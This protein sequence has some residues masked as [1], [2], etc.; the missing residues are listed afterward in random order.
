[1]RIL[2]AD[3]NDFSAFEGNEDSRVARR[4]RKFGIFMRESRRICGTIGPRRV[5][6]VSVTG[7]SWIAMNAIYYA[8]VE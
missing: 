7:V 1:M 3:V 6:G 8:L 4:G 2:V 5:E